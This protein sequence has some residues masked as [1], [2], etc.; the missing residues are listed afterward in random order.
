RL[1]SDHVPLEVPSIVNGSVSLRTANFQDKHSF[2]RPP[3]GLEEAAIRLRV[4]EDVVEK[5]GIREPSVLLG[6]RTV[7]HSRTGAEEDPL[8]IVR[9]KTNLGAG[10]VLGRPARCRGATHRQKQGGEA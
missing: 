9:W 3:P 2:V 4:D 8:P 7:S 1:D 6:Q 5:R 10:D